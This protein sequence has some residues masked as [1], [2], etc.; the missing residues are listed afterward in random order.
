MKIAFAHRMTLLLMTA[1]LLFGVSGARAAFRFE[2]QYKTTLTADDR[3]IGSLKGNYLVYDHPQITLYD[4]DGKKLFVKKIDYTARPI[5]S[6]NGKHV[7]IV[8]YDSKSPTDLKTLRID[9]LDLAG[10]KQWTFNKPTPNSFMLGNNGAIFGIE[11]VE[12]LSPTRV[13][14]FD[15]FGALLNMLTFKEYRGLAISPSGL[16]LA[17]DDGK[18]GLFVYDSTGNQLAILPSAK[19]YVFDNDDRYLGS[20]GHIAVGQAV[21]VRQ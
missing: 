1:L 17:V 14:L 8:T 13:H 20:T 3:V 11:G 16:K 4:P 12:G 15:Q 21:C 18:D 2:S 9:F 6:P 7:A 10:K 19:Q 5:L